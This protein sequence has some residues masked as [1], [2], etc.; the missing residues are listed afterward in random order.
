MT[1]P[2]PLP[3]MQINLE[4]RVRNVSLSR[5]QGLRPV[6]EAIANSIDAIEDKNADGTVEIRILRDLSRQVLF[7]GD[8]GLHPI[9]AFEITDTGVGFTAR[10]WQAFQESDTTVKAAQGGKG[11]GRL[12]YL[13]AFDRAEVASTF[14]EDGKWFR[15]DFSFRLPT[16]IVDSQ[17][18][19]VSPSRTTTIVR[20]VGFNER[21]RKETPRTGKAIATRIVEHCMERFV[22]GKCPTLTLHDDE[23]FDL[24]EHFRGAHLNIGR[25]GRVQGER[26]TLFSGPCACVDRLW[27][28][29]PSVL[30]CPGPFR[31]F[32]TTEFARFTTIHQLW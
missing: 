28:S 18:T 29:P 26:P 12:L 10:N 15:R 11:I 13:K 25:T 30:L 16:G 31:V 23:V 4:G 8:T 14:E 9:H 5:K 27:R 2:S 21:Y 1:S 6:F 19:E 24:W 7:D 22:L 20:L 32:G 17:V 3:V